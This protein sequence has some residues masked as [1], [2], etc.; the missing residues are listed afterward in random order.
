MRA[1]DSHAVSWPPSPRSK[2]VL[3]VA[4][5]LALLWVLFLLYEYQTTRRPFGRLPG[6]PPLDRLTA[7][8]PPAYVQGFYGPPDATLASP[9]GVAAS[10]S[11]DR[12][13]ATASAG[14]R[15][16]LVFD[17]TGRPLNRLF[18]PDTVPAGRY[19]LYVAVD[20]TGTV[21]VSDRIRAVIDVYDPTGDY[22]G[23]YEPAD[24]PPV[25][26]MAL[27]F[28]RAGNFYV[29]DLP[30][31]QHRLL[32]YDRSGRLTLAAGTQGAGAGEF[33]FPN[34]VAV[35]DRGRIYV[36]DSNN[37]RVQI[38]D[39]AGQVLEVVGR[40]GQGVLGIPRGVA[41]DEKRRLFIV[42]TAS[43]AVE[44]WDVAGTPKRLY[45]VGGEG[46]GHAQFLYP[47][48]IALDATGR[49]YVTDRLNDRLQVW[50]Y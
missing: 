3:A 38:L 7:R 11:G 35:D 41:V 47:N 17:R 50:S 36:S 22:R 28:D 44:V 31:G 49:V 43:H 37:G 39:P 23:I 33:S 26:P 18:P 4:L 40:G 24:E 34:G 42:D 19:P 27:A 20:A 16:T 10:P 15:V 30:E 1:L 9:L 14:D 2:L 21:Y 25:A 48:G 13:Y 12:L 45:T 5:G 6:A 8:Q 32:V 46:A 29:T